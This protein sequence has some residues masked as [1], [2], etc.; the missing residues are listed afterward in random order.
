[1]RVTVGQTTERAATSPSLTAEERGN[2]ALELARVLFVNGQSTRQTLLATETL[3]RAL[4]L[5]A[6]LMVRWGELQ[7]RGGDVS[8]PG[9]GRFHLSVAADPTVVVMGRV[10]AAMRV[11]DEA[12]AGRLAPAA[13]GDAIRAAAAVP[14][15]PTWLFALAA[16]ACA[17]ALSVI[18]G[19]EH[20]AGGALIFASAAAGGVLRR[21]VARVAANPL[22]QPF[23]A[24]LLAGIVGAAAARAGMS[25]SLRLVAACPC[26]VLVPGPPVINGALDLARGR[27][28]LGGARW[29]FAGMVILAICCGLLIGMALLGVP[30]PVEAAGVAVPLWMDAVAAGIAVACFSIFFSMPA[31]MM[32]WPVAVGMLAHALR[33]WL[34]NGMVGAV[35]TGALAACLLVGLILT[36]VARRWHMPFAGVGF[37]AVVSMMPGVYLFRMASGLEII[38]RRAQASPEVVSATVADG[39]TALAIVLEMCLGLIVPKLLIDSALDGWQKG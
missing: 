10:S 28:H 38:A 37:A 2:L 17:A 7:L 14:P 32:A 13:I 33:W 39:A 25:W 3:S 19:L 27:V 21:M 24:A 26:M 18:F 34:I 11:A 9:S 1:M 6:Q 12:A 36:P 5:D 20:A 8:E 31:E 29:M 16:G 23:A 15:S 30:F 22:A 35:P 4:G